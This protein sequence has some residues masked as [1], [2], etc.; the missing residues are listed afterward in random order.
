MNI[1]TRRLRRDYEKIK[2][3]L[4]GSKYVSVAA[5]S[6]DPPTHYRVIYRVPGLAWDESTHSARRIDEHVVD[7]NL[8]LG[9]PKQKPRC[10]ISTPIWHPNVGD[11]VCIEDDWSAGVPLV[12]IIA[13]V[14]DMIQY[15]NYNL[16]S[17]VNKPAAQW[18]ARNEGLLLSLIPVGDRVD[19]IPPESKEEMEIDIVLKAQ[20]D[21]LSI[22]LGP[23]RERRE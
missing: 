6:G 8:P 2:K 1:R 11:Y 3:E 7:I 13:H 10:T 21:D 16:R 12:D 17:P 9:Y 5:V 18:A 20:Q 19:I 4:G 23:V 15:R 14:G 22:E